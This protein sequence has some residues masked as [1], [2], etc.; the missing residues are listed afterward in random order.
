M[1]KVIASMDI[2]AQKLWI[3]ASDEVMYFHILIGKYEPRLNYT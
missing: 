3:T 2:A 1:S